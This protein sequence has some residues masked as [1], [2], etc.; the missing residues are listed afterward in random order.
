MKIKTSEEY[1]ALM[2]SLEHGARVWQGVWSAMGSAEHHGMA[3]FAGYE[4]HE[5]LE[6]AEQVAQHLAEQ[7]Q[8]VMFG[9][10]KAPAC[11][12]ESEMTAMDAVCEADEQIMVAAKA[13]HSAAVEAGERTFFLD[14]LMKKMARER[15]EVAEVKTLLAGVASP[16]GMDQLNRMMMEK[17]SGHHG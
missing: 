9:A 4:A 12:Y 3:A 2:N 10:I 13:V 5:R 8:Q 16:E 1:H 17:Y 11:I 6:Y 14:Q 15:A 7:G